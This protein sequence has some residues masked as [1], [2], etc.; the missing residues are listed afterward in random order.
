M[1]EI[2]IYTQAQPLAVKE[3]QGQ[4]VITF[5]DIDTLHQRPEGT[6]S[7]NFRANRVRF[8]EGED[9]FTV[10]L[11]ADEIRRQFGA[12]KNAGRSM[13]VLTKMGYLMLVKS[14]T[15]DLA[16]MVQRQLVRSYFEAQA[17]QPPVRMLPMVEREK[18]PLPRMRTLPQAVK[19]I[20]AKDP[21]T[22]LSYWSLRRWVKEGLI[23]TVQPGKCPLV[24]MDT[25]GRFMEGGGP[26][27][28]H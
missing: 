12:G 21:G 2:A 20:Q 9:F 15:D 27:G 10:E 8:I 26:G 1:N 22:Y 24:N 23:P 28:Q 7:R 16:W 14:F 13:I 18:K 6:A 5:K 11:T 19:E 17:P 25:L 4:R 3:Y